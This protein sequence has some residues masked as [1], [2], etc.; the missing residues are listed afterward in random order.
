MMPLDFAGTSTSA[1]IVYDTLSRLGDSTD[2]R[3]SIAEWYSKRVCPAFRPGRCEN[4]IAGLSA[5]SGKTLYLL[6][7][8]TKTRLSCS[9]L[10]GYCAATLSFC[11]QSV[12]TWKSS[13]LAFV[14][15]VWDS[16]FLQF[17]SDV[18]HTGITLAI[19]P[20]L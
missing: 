9:S 19:Q 2:V 3:F 20:S 7:S 1:A 4:A 17:G 8:S 5:L 13:H 12:S 14:H 16:G 10:S 6:A 11:V 15:G 18:M